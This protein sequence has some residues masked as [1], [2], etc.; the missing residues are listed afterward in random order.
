M[1]TDQPAHDESI[2]K[3]QPFVRHTKHVPDSISDPAL[4]DAPGN[5][6][7]DEGGALSPNQGGAHAQTEP[8]ES[9]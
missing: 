2:A 1:S 4:G 5:D 8:D 9:D 7:A 3:T 6:W